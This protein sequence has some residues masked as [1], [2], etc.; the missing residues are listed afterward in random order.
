MP[1]L[2]VEETYQDTALSHVDIPFAIA[3]TFPSL[4]MRH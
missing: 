1:T 3:S 2:E 4:H